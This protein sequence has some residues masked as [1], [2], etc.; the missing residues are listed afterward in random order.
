MT[1]IDIHITLSPKE[2]RAYD[3]MRKDLAAEMD[4]GSLL[5]APNALAKIMKLRQITAGF[6]RDTQS[7]EVH[8][9]GHTKRRAVKEVVETQLAGEN[10][11][12]VF[13]YFR[14]ECRMIAESLKAKG[15]T[16]EVITGA[17]SVK[18]RL[19][20]RERFADVSGNPGRIILVAQARAMSLSVNELVTAQNAVFASLSER[21]NDWVQSRDR[22][23]R[24]GQKGSHVTFWNVYAPGTVDEVMLDR[25]KD[26]G[27]LEKALLDHIRATPR[28]R[29]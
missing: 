10:R 2:Q 13:A 4:D 25:H 26:R 15:V 3:E 9:I 12:V 8:E 16:V 21:R 6:A 14:S 19:A 28:R 17:T 29:L 5:T 23:D 27:D 1:D 20:I 7:E 11:V 22:L 18:D 24:N